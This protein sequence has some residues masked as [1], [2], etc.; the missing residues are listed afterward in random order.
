[1]TNR[2]SQYSSDSQ[3]FGFLCRLLCY[4]HRPL[5]VHREGAAPAGQGRGPQ[6][7][8]HVGQVVAVKTKWLVIDY[9]H[10]IRAFTI[11][12]ESQQGMSS[13]Q[14]SLCHWLSL[15][16]RIVSL[17]SVDSDNVGKMESGPKVCFMLQVF[18]SLL[19][20]IRCIQST[21]TSNFTEQTKDPPIWE[22]LDSVPAQIK[23][24][25]RSCQHT[26]PTRPFSRR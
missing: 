26:W 23:P 6:C 10:K 3:T 14:L 12:T 24:Q 17:L 22:V 16:F 18:H 19:R 21:F 25:S 9:W 8:E 4:H 7:L 20:N 2:Y 5:E 13:L 1:M 11:R 15:N